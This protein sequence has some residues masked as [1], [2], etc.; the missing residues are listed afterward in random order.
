MLLSPSEP[1][2]EVQATRFCAPPV[3]DADAVA[4]L[5]A[6]DPDG[7]AGLLERV[8]STYAQSLERLLG[9]LRVARGDNDANGQRHVAHTLKSS[10]ASVGALALSVLCADVE[11][12]LREGQ[13]T[14]IDAELDS[15]ASEGQRVLAGLTQR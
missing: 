14:G 5:T 8:L 7:A 12:R 15:L 10:S 3:L 2:E 11:R 9:Q 13:M 4:R 1:S 6:L